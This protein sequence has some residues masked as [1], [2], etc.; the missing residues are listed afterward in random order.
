M[1]NGVR[2]FGGSK[3]YILWSFSR[4]SS[5]YRIAA[6]HPCDFSIDFSSISSIIVHF[7]GFL[8]GLGIQEQAAQWYAGHQ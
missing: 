7:P 4:H 1:N 6:S 2:I 3:G 5:L 8:I